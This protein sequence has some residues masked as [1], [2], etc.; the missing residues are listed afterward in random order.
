VNDS[1]YLRVFMKFPEYLEE[2]ET[3][4]AGR[5]LGNE[6]KQAARELM[7]GKELYDAVGEGLGLRAV[8]CRDGAMSII[9]KWARE[10]TE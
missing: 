4:A 8:E 2:F 1:D 10:K 6:V 5:G 3:I 9:K 7:V